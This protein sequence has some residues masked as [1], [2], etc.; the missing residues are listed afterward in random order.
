[1]RLLLDTHCW[2]WLQAE[3]ERFS[4]RVLAELRKPTNELFFSAAST[5]EI[6][7]K[8]ALGKLALPLPPKD[9]IPS[10]MQR[11][12]TQP[13]PIAHAHA[14]AV[15]Q[16]PDHHRDPFDRILIAQAQVE[17]LVVLTADRLFALYEV[18]TLNPS[19]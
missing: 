9:Y 2:L 14:L 8:Y 1:M 17:N 16:L 3:P 7:I 6:C 13:L 11:S 19:V 5:W 4:P 10:R 15:S 12:G 18:N